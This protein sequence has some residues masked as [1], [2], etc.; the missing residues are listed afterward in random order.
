VNQ[1]D[2]FAAPPMEVQ[3]IAPNAVGVY[4]DDAAE[5]FTLPLDKTGW[6]GLPL[7]EV[8]LLRLPE[9]WLQAT[10]VQTPVAGF[11]WGLCERFGGGYHE[12]RAKALKRA[13]CTLLAFCIGNQGDGA[14][15]ARIGRWAQT[16]A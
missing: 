14:Y 13:K 5:A 3:A 4:P 7:A 10:R 1:L 6:R 9:G 11:G 8:R 16:L 2:L 12:S 15:R